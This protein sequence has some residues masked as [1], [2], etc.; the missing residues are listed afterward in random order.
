MKT[1]FEVKEGLNV[2]DFSPIAPGIYFTKELGA[3]QYCGKL[4]KAQ[5]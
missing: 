3:T 5:D 4:I 2:L 1:T